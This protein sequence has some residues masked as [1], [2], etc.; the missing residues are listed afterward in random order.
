ML[1]EGGRESKQLIFRTKRTDQREW[2]SGLGF[3]LR[4][5]NRTFCLPGQK[6]NSE[7]TFF[8]LFR[9]EKKMKKIQ[10]NVRQN[11]ELHYETDY[12]ITKYPLRSY[13]VVGIVSMLFSS[14]FF[15]FE[16]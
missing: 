14:R 6:K 13:S 4:T 1:V 11:R 15:F 16:K 9:S 2:N 8:L 7:K 5:K 3:F 12:I 10:P